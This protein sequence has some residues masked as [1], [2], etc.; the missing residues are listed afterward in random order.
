MFL[1]GAVSVIMII[2]GGFRYTTSQGDQAKLQ[3][4]K[5][6]VMYSVIGLAIAIFGYAII[7]FVISSFIG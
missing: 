5:N 6:T 1:I 4:A 3:T 2:V 7:S